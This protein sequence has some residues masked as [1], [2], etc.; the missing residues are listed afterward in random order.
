MIPSSW[1]LNCTLVIC[2]WHSFVKFCP[3]EILFSTLFSR[4]PWTLRLEERWVF[5]T[6]VLLLGQ[7]ISVVL[8]F[9]VTLTSTSITQ[10][11]GF[12]ISSEL[13]Y[14]I[15]SM[16][17][18]RHMLDLFFTWNYSTSDS[19]NS[20][21]PDHKL[22]AVLRS[23]SPTPST[24]VLWSYWALH[25]LIYF[26][27]IC[28]LFYLSH[29][30]PQWL[31]LVKFSSL[32]PPHLHVD[33]LSGHHIH[34]HLFPSISISCASPHPVMTHTQSPVDSKFPVLLTCLLLLPAA[35]LT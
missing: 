11:F 23:H 20:N 26:L 30:S 22:L 33:L 8:R 2:R 25:P 24:P 19:I 32:P 35:F 21:I 17:F 28:L 34:Y 15:L 18:N 1:G 4:T 3:A 29:L 13:L 16:L 27:P 14:T 6:P 10:Q 7:I 9:W 12:L 31:G 5:P